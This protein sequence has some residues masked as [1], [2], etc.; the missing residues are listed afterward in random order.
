ML[1]EVSVKV[2]MKVLAI[3]SEKKYWWKYWQFS[4]EV[5]V[6]VLAILSKSIIT[7]PANGLAKI[8]LQG[9]Q[10]FG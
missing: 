8:V 3:L 1:A 7:N 6:S 4:S 2:L 10:A 5:S 9:Q